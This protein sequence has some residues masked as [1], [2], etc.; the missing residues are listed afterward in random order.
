M[1]PM[2]V[3]K[4]RLQ[5]P[6]STHKGLWDCMSQIAKEEGLRPFFRY[7]N[8]TQSHTNHTRNHTQITHAITRKSHTKSI[9]KKHMQQSNAKSAL[10]K[11]TQPHAEGYQS[12][13]CD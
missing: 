6:G 9:Y 4:Q 3:V 10:K 2:D 13:A 8:H 11:H 1:L 5:L 7:A 12:Q